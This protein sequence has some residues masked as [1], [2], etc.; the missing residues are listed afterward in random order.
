M[1]LRMG[2]VDA[3]GYVPCVVGDR[4]VQASELE[5]AKRHSYYAATVR[6]R[7]EHELFQFL[8]RGS[9]GNRYKVV[10]AIGDSNVDVKCSCIAGQ[11]NRRCWHVTALLDGDITN[12]LSDNTG[13]VA[14]LHDLIQKFGLGSTVRRRSRDVPFRKG[15]L[16]P[17]ASLPATFGSIR[18]A[19]NLAG[20]TVVFTGTLATMTRG[21]AK[22]RAE[23]LGAKVAGSVSKKTDYL[24]IGAEAGS[25]ARKAAELGVE[26][27]SEPAWL[28]LIG[29]G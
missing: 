17:A 28:A 29:G 5:Y 23:A 19:D 6:R 14:K 7:E 2:K 12:L 16:S 1:S 4:R 27:L 3:I 11:N 26:T 20:K 21:E 25:K 8:V 15:R 18:Q 13:D 24:V 22:A 10:V 9:S